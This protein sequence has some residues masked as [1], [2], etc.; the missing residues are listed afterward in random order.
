MQ[1]DTVLLN[2]HWIEELKSLPVVAHVSSHLVAVRIGIRLLTATFDSFIFLFL[3]KKGRM[4]ALLKQKSK[5][6]IQRKERKIYE[7]AD[8][9][10]RRK[11]N[12][13]N[14]A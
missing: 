9:F 6:V 2:D 11:L 3:Q 5:V 14:L 12:E 7:V 8:V 1:E 4:V 10:N 13:S